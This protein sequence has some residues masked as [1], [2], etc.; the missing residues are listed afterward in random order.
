MAITDEERDRRF[1]AY[2]DR[3]DEG[4]KKLVQKLA[5]EFGTTFYVETTGGGCMA[6]MAKVEGYG[7]MITDASD[8][9][10][11]MDERKRARKTGSPCG[12]G[13]GVYPIYA[14]DGKHWD[15]GSRSFLDEGQCGKPEHAV[16]G[17][18]AVGWASC[19]QADK[20]PQLIQL[21]KL[22]IKSVGTFGPDGP[23]WDHIDPALLKESK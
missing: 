8:I 17:A 1:W 18:D 21:I 5:K 16:F 15:S 11:T 2:M 12:Y 13:V 3:Y 22:A 7:L 23:G 20:A 10:S 19:P 4:Y 14:C 6:I 9:L